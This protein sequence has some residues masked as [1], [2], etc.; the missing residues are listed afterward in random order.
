MLL[1]T[2]A[3]AKCGRCGRNPREAQAVGRELKKTTVLQELREAH[4]FL[5]M[6]RWGHDWCCQGDEERWLAKQKPCDDTEAIFNPLDN[7][8][9]DDA[10]PPAAAPPAAGKAEVAA[11]APPKAKAPMPTT[12]KRPA[13]GPPVPRLRSRTPERGP[14]GETGLRGATGA[15]GPPG[16]RGPAGPPGPPGEAGAAGPPGEPT[17]SG[18]L[19]RLTMELREFVQAEIRRCLPGELRELVQEVV[20]REVS[21]NMNRRSRS[22]SGPRSRSPRRNTRGDLISNT[23]MRAAAHRVAQQIMR[24]RSPSFS[25]RPRHEGRREGRRD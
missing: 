7:D 24:A 5:C 3:D 23:A 4:P 1:S 8:D 25:R 12:P 6:P 15:A 14:K 2:M 21:D 9:D 19:A 22:R 17:D 11:P 13:L 20:H 16:E 18:F 10:A